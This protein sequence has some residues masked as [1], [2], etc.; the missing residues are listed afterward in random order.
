M[1]ELVLYTGYTTYQDDTIETLLE[2]C[3]GVLLLHPVLRA[4]ARLLLLPLCYASTW[5]VHDNVEVHTENTDSRV[6]PGTKIDM[7]L[8]TETEVAGL[9]EVL[10][11]EFVL[12][13]LEATLK[14]L[15]SLG[16]TN[17]DMDRDLLVTTDT[18]GTD[19]VTGLGGNGGL[20]RELLENLGGTGETI[21]GLSDGD[22]YRGRDI[23]ST[24]R[25]TQESEG[26]ALRTSLSIRISFIGLVGAVFCSA[27][28]HSLP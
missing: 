17:G 25:S 13:D 28:Q 19:G 21:T 3:H 6:V 8:N 18:E 4:N 12:L 5:P 20:T 22:V 27:C 9:R 2:P 1:S 15:L 14:D 16:A 11:T 7:L 24:R 26:Y 23:R 10:A